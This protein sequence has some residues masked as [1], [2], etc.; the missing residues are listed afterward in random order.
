M[1][2]ALIEESGEVPDRQSVEEIVN[3]FYKEHDLD[4]YHTI[5]I[6]FLDDTDIRTYNKRLFTLDRPTDVLCV[7]LDEQ[8]GE[9]EYLWGEIYI[10]T[11]TAKREA[12]RRGIP[13]KNEVLLYLAHGLYHLTGI[14]DS[15]EKERSEIWKKQLGLLE[16]C[17]YTPATF[18]EDE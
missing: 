5:N 12:S 4:P 9:D 18:L 3:A 15:T 17:G 11:E 16:K 2:A 8:F 6:I 14:E 13:W 7:N 1:I 10:S